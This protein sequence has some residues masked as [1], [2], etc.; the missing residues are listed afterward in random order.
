MQS[1]DAVFDYLTDPRESLIIE[2][3]VSPTEVRFTPL[4]LEP[5]SWFLDEF[6]ISDRQDDDDD[7]LVITLARLA[8][9]SDRMRPSG[10][11]SR[12]MRTSCSLKALQ[13]FAH[14]GKE[15]RRSLSESI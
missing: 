5:A 2:L 6:P 8:Q 9:F 4:R 7:Q 11:R 12:R 14:G 13:T 10:N 3:R 15:S 1:P